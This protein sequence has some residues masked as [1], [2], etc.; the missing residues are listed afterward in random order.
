MKKG[1]VELKPENIFLRGVTYFHYEGLYNE[2]LNTETV[3]ENTEYV[4][5]FPVK[6]SKQNKNKYDASLFHVATKIGCRPWGYEDLSL[7]YRLY[8]SSNKLELALNYANSSNDWNEC[9]EIDMNYLDNEEI[10]FI[11]NWFVGQ[12]DEKISE[13]AMKSYGLTDDNYIGS[14]FDLLETKCCIK[15]YVKNEECF[16]IK[17]EN[18]FD[19]HNLS[20]IKCSVYCNKETMEA[21]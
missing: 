19:L 20:K 8:S 13:L 16:R 11:R 10:D 14:R 4:I 2:N 21:I 5:L 18:I 1:L 9:I 3:S 17:A 7:C 12:A 15:W 6:R